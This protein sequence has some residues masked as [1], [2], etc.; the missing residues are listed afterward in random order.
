MYKVCTKVLQDHDRPE[1][2][3]QVGRPAPKGRTSYPCYAFLILP[4]TTASTIEDTNIPEKNTKVAALRPT[5][6]NPA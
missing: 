5:A 2:K 1:V 3:R 6:K 4:K